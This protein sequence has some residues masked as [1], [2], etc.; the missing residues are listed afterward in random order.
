MV[1]ELLERRVGIPTAAI[2]SAGNKAFTESLGIYDEVVTYDAIE[3]A[4]VASPAV[5]ID[6]TGA[7][8]WRRAVYQH[9]APSLSCGVLIGFTHPGADVAPPGC[10]IRSRSSSSRR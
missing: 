10:P 4:A 2:T 5:F 3:S 7:A 9:F 8:K 6:F 1:D